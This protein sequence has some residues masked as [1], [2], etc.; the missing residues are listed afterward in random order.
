MDETIGY[1]IEFNLE[2]DCWSTQTKKYD[3]H[4]LKIDLLESVLN[5]RTNALYTS[6]RLN[7][8]EK[9]VREFRKNLKF[10]P[11][12]LM[13][14]SFLMPPVQGRKRDAFLNFCVKLEGTVTQLISSYFPMNF[15]VNIAEGFESWGIT[16]IDRN[17]DHKKELISQL[18]T[19]YSVYNT[20][21]RKITFNDIIENRTVQNFDTLDWKILRELISGGYFEENR[22]IDYRHLAGSLGIS[23]STI[24]RRT[25]KIEREGLLNLLSMFRNNK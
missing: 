1:F 10:N 5:Q 19:L 23:I 24:S 4:E 2:H 15:H 16:F 22:V 3:Y 8:T 13:V 11:H 14:N 9:A 18:K 25:R 17:E 6:V 21:E 20:T 12:I 7:G